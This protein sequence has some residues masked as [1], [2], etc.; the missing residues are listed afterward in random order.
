MH[1]PTYRL[2][3]PSGQAVV[4][5]R[6]TSGR[7]DVYLGVH[8]SPENRKE[9]ARVIVEVAASGGTMPTASPTIAEMLLAFWKHI[10]SHYP[11]GSSHID[12]YRVSNKIGT[13]KHFGRTLLPLGSRRY[14]ELPKGRVYS[15][16]LSG[17]ILSPA[18][19]G[20]VE[21][22]RGLQRRP[23]KTNREM[24][25]NQRTS[26]IAPIIHRSKNQSRADAPTH[27]FLHRRTHQGERRVRQ[28]GV[29]PETGNQLKL[30]TLVPWPS[31]VFALVPLLGF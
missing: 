8:N 28:M 9:Y 12:Q 10:Q 25:R 11:P 17:N 1:L 27:A 23:N 15:D 14:D 26:E 24:P 21:S 20:C 13:C 7:R 22:N 4:T 5:I 29:S 3:K 2:H 30:G 19:R 18:G 31:R 6:T 16:G